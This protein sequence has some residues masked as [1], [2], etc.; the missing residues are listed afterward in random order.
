MSEFTITVTD[1]CVSVSKVKDGRSH[2]C[3]SM[4]LIDDYWFLNRCLV[5][6]PYR[7]TGLGTRMIGI[8]QD[9]ARG[10]KIVVTPGGY[11]MKLRDQIAFYE[12]CGFKKVDD[13]WEYQ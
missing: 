13:H 4:S 2:G 9:N 7:R 1:E 5:Q 11:N 10:L 6:E 3:A 12:S 8:L